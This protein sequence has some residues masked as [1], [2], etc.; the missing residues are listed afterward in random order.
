MTLWV[1]GGC[2]V[3]YSVGAPRCPQCDANG[4]IEQGGK[5]HMAKI[6]AE[7]GATQYVD[8]A[9]GAVPAEEWVAAHGPG[10]ELVGP[11]APEG[12]DSDQDAPEDE[13]NEPETVHGSGTVEVEDLAGGQDDGTDDESDTDG[14]GVPDGTA[15]AVAAWVADATGAPGDT[16]SDRA[17]RALAAEEARP[18][19]RAGLM[20][21]LH[22]VAE[23]A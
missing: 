6:A 16:Q 22:R 1:C 5:E 10:V 15:R 12:E 14:D 4:P 20:T 18:S 2:G 11:G 21:D 23:S 3:A 17:R 13:G 19:P 7:G 9:E 8:D